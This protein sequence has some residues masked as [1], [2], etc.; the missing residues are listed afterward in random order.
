MR[1]KVWLIRLPWK[2]ETAC[3]NHAAQ[4]ILPPSF[5][6]R[7]SRSEREDGGWIPSGGAN[8]VQWRNGN[9]AVCKTVMSRLD[10]GLHLH[11]LVARMDRPPP[12]KRMHAGSNPAESSFT[13]SGELAERQGIAVLTRRD[14]RVGQVRLLHSPPTHFQPAG[15]A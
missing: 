11:A 1:G 9:A 7:M 8:T 3:S 12:S 14:L 13:K 5:N 2:Q 4:T 6:A 10:T 15:L